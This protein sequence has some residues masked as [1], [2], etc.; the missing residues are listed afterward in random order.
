MSSKPSITS[1]LRRS[2][3]FRTGALLTAIAVLALISMVS[4]IFI[5]DST[6]GDAAAINLAGSLRMLS[7]RT[8]AAV[9]Q[10]N[11]ADLQQTKQLIEQVL[12]NPQL[13][14]VIP[15][16]T[17]NEIHQAFTALKQ[18]WLTHV[19]PALP[20]HTAIEP[21]LQMVQRANQ[22]VSLIQAD[23]EN[24]LRLLGMI[25]GITMF[26]TAILLFAAMYEV[27]TNIVTPLRTLVAAAE[28][29]GQGN[30]SARIE[31]ERD[32]ELT[33]LGHAFNAMADDLSRIYRE[34]ETRVNDKTSE[35]SRTIHAL[36]FI[37]ETSR[38]VVENTDTQ[39]RLKNILT[40]LQQTMN[41]HDIKLHI[42]YTPNQPAFHLITATDEITSLSHINHEHLTSFTI[43][44]AGYV[45]GELLI[46]DRAYPLDH[47]QREVLESVADLIATSLT[48]DYQ[49]E[50]GQ[51]L[52]LM[53]ERTVIA[54]ELHDS[55]AQ[56]LSYLKIQVSRLKT[57]IGKASGTNN[58]NVVIDELEEGLNSA[59]RQ[60]R[61]LLTTF[62]LKI[63]KPGLE[64]ALRTTVEEYSSRSD[65]HISLHFALQ[66][67][68]HAN[69]EIHILQI[70]REAIA[71]II[72]HA[73]ATQADISVTENH[74]DILVSIS[75]NG[76]GLSANPQR[77][78][79]HGLTIMQER[80][81]T[82]GGHLTWTTPP[83][84]GTHILLVFN[85]HAM[86]NA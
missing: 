78:H 1:T 40:S 54:R 46:S 45:F 50:Q 68:L 69:Q 7:Y 86:V 82:L 63:D 19:S 48:L 9:Q 25:Q 77:M 58:V 12:S 36:R 64:A 67:P 79:H 34:L 31:Y 83:G 30:F 13:L 21:T 5:S 24:K 23:A 35:L 81:N 16:D 59:Y 17:N 49:G 71:N 38:L 75:D 61:E 85:R 11:N 62:R 39:L 15:E 27:H 8:V 6:D 60:L 53:E 4:A 37:N 84:G 14:N 3:V 20:E 65:V 76:V 44:N 56:S 70:V 55:L 32:D 28:S 43:A 51:R 18:H 80:A 29:M 26:I 33:V 22:L 72:Q 47:W 2:L 41:L 42:T 57:T 52:A 66:Q 73:Q 74:N 10:N